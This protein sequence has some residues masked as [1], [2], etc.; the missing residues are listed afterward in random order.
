[1]AGELGET[2]ALV[3]FPEGANFTEER[4]RRGIERLE[5]AGHDDAGRVRPARCAT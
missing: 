5:E 3:I 4:R 1:M 2:A